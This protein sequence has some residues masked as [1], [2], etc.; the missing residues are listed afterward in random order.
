[1]LELYLNKDFED[2]YEDFHNFYNLDLISE[3]VLDKLKIPGKLKAAGDFI[4]TA[5]NT[6]NMDV[7]DVV[8]K[9]K[10]K[11]LFKFLA[12]F[13]FSFKN[14]FEFVKKGHENY[15]KLVGI[16]AEYIH[17]TGV[18]QWTEAKLKD[19]T[20]YLDKHP[21]LK[22][23]GGVAVAGILVYIW[24]NMTF[25]GDA[26]YDFNMSDILA[27]LSGNFDLSQIFAGPQGIKLLMLFGTGLAGLSFPWPG[28]QSVQFTSAVLSTFLINKYKKLKEWNIKMSKFDKIY[29]NTINVLTENSDI[30]SL[31]EPYQRVF[32]GDK[33]N[34]AS[35]AY[36]FIDYAAQGN[37]AILNDIFDGTGPIEKKLVKSTIQTDRPKKS[38]PE[39]DSTRY[40]KLLSKLSK[41]QSVAKGT[42]T[43]D[44]HISYELFK[45]GS[46]NFL[47]IS[48]TKHKVGKIIKF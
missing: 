47:H 18:G 35:E 2:L 5:K 37:S 14:I 33:G 28:A 42:D 34:V 20:D 29:E 26:S 7:K 12:K 32:R 38:L 16:I 27:A 3:G 36:K 39:L 30:D 21:K 10:D 13:K 22:K 46:D 4:K 40:N 48:N 43:W 24:L 8:K 1:M 25:T 6:L 11:Q 15:Q 41:A 9:L 31:M 23:V 17:K 45:L 19:L 44:G